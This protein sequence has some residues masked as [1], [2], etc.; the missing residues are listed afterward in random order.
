MGLDERFEAKKWHLFLNIF[1]VGYI[2]CVTHVVYQ[3]KIDLQI[4]GFA[5][6]SIVT[7]IWRYGGLSCFTSER[8]V[9]PAHSTGHNLARKAAA[10]NKRSASWLAR[11]SRLYPSDRRLSVLLHESPEK[12][13]LRKLWP[14]NTK[15][16]HH[17]LIKTCM[18]FLRYEEYQWR[19]FLLYLKG[20][21]TTLFFFLCIF[22]YD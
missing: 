18:T 8:L 1:C 9:L 2:H 7:G 14:R 4:H 17:L 15:S 10:K 5:R 19:C 6:L 22:K 12:Y 20:K 21:Q 3:I 16:C 13:R 11:Q